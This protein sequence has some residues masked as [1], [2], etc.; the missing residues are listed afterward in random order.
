[1]AQTQRNF[2]LDLIRALAILMVIASHEFAK[3]EVLGHV[4]VE[5]F[6]VLSGFLIGGIFLRTIVLNSDAKWR[7]ITEFWRRRWWRTLPSYFLFLALIA[8]LSLCRGDALPSHFERYLFF[9]QNLFWPMPNFYVVSWSLAVEEWFY[10]LMPLIYFCFMRTLK[11]RRSAF[12]ATVIILFW[13]PM[14]LRFSIGSRQNYE[15][16]RFTVLY[17]LDAMMVGVLAAAIADQRRAFWIKLKPLAVIG[18]VGLVVLGILDFRTKGAAPTLPPTVMYSLL[19]W[20]A[21]L[22]LPGMSSWTTVSL[23]IRKPVEFVALTSYSAYLSHTVILFISEWWIEPHFR[24]AFAYCAKLAS[25]LV[26]FLVSF[27]LFKFFEIPMTARRGPQ[28]VTAVDEVP[29]VDLVA[30]SVELTTS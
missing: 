22:L 8:A 14:A 4:A 9:G 25:F 7:D 12:I 18:V 29:H 1:M 30:S 28:R 2:G 21:V 6:F 17:R 5:M 15:A 26:M 13:V 11:G 27:L 10:L 16:I 20:S 23:R 24:G 3:L 19:P